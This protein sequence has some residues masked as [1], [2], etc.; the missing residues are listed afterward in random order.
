MKPAQTLKHTRNTT[1][2]ILSRGFVRFTGHVGKKHPSS[3]KERFETA[4]GPELLLN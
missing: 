1:V 3:Q 4:Y 2:I